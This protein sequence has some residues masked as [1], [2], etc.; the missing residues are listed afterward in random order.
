MYGYISY[1][2]C[3]QEALRDAQGVLNKDSEVISLTLVMIGGGGA[4]FA[5]D[6]L[7]IFLVKISPPD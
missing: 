1:L 3:I 5:H 4:L 2:H 7:F 6:F